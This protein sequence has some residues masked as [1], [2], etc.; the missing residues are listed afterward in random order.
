[1]AQR[2]TRGGALL[3]VRALV[4]GPPRQRGTVTSLERAGAPE[5]AVLSRPRQSHPVLAGACGD[6]TAMFITT[7]A[8]ACAAVECTIR[9]ARGELRLAPSRRGWMKPCRGGD[10]HA[11]DFTPGAPKRSAS[12]RCLFSVVTGPATDWWQSLPAFVAAACRRSE[13]L[14]GKDIPRNCN[15]APRIPRPPGGLA[16]F[17][18]RRPQKFRQVALGPLRLS[19]E[20]VDDDVSHYH[21]HGRIPVTSLGPAPPSPE[22]V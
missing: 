19:S 16:N 2:L 13:G 12:G 17:E 20:R 10:P 11:R 4:S 7:P 5:G 6:C 15:A 14:R 21:R 9:P 18:K 1:M 3:R 8:S 22:A